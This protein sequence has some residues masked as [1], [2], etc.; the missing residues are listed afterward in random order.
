MQDVAKGL[1][2]ALEDSVRDGWRQVAHIQ[3]A[4]V[5][6]VIPRPGLPASAA[7]AAS[8]GA[9]ARGTPLILLAPTQLC[10]EGLVLVVHFGCTPS[11]YSGSAVLRLFSAK[12]TCS[13]GAS[14]LAGYAFGGIPVMSIMQISG[15]LLQISSI[16]VDTI[17]RQHEANRLTDN[18]ARAS[19]A[20]NITLVLLLHLLLDGIGQLVDLLRLVG[21]L[22]LSVAILPTQVAVLVILQG[23]CSKS[24]PPHHG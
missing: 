2:E 12:A 24:P 7:A 3:L 5:G 17:Y 14:M 4:I 13:S 15:I 6:Q 23:T 18:L 9:H 10:Q 20:S 22:E 21:A 11:T 16:A 1:H 8:H 19:H